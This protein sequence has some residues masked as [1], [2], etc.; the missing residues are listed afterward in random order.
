MDP[1]RPGLWHNPD[2]VKLWAAAT[3]S[4]FGS[5][6]TRTALP[7]TAI[8]VLK[9]TPVQIALLAA[10]DLASQFLV[11]LVAGAWADRL[12]RRPIMI[13][14]DLGRAALLGTIPLAAFFHAL[15]IEQLYAV[16][17][18]TGILTVF[19]DVADQSYLP[20]L[21]RREQLVEGNGKLSAS[22][23]IAEVG[24]FGL[25]GWLVQLLTGPIAILIDALSFLWSALFV[26]LI[27]APE[28]APAPPG[29]GQSIRAE[30]AEGLRVVLGNPLLRA[31]AGCTL[32]AN[33]SFRISGA[34]FLL[35]TTRELGFQPGI[36]GMI[37]AVGGVSSLLGALVA[38]RT[39]HRFGAGPVMIAGVVLMGVSMLLIPLAQGATMLALLL[40]VAQQL[41]DGAFT[42]YDITQVSLRQAITPERVLGRANASIR[43]SML[44]AML[45]GSLL[46]GLLGETIGLRATLTAAAGGILLSA[47]W[48]ILSPLRTLRAPLEPA[49]EKEI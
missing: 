43:F 3:I 15:R 22:A 41:G 21:V 30:I 17:F 48:L 47:L 45:A 42:V 12:R 35:F 32:T 16:A 23:S 1:H 13:A 39:A 24:A 26:G 37:F 49:S 36:Q 34:V 5:L 7:F 29:G 38:G 11:G 20:T 40:L 27:R 25:S 18:L 2:F 33:L 19:F 9:A 31:I 8:L 10:A 44:G 14:A 6:I 28:P 46:G 4:I